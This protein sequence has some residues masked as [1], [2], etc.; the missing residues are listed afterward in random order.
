[1]SA[2]GD[3]DLDWLVAGSGDFSA[4]TVLDVH[5]SRHLLTT[6]RGRTSFWAG[7]ASERRWS[8]R[9]NMVRHWPAELTVPK[10]QSPDGTTSGGGETRPTP[11]GSASQACLV[12]PRSPAIRPSQSKSYGS[13]RAPSELWA[14][15]GMRSPTPYGQG[16]HRELLG[17]ARYQLEGEADAAPGLASHPLGSRPS[18][19]TRARHM[20]THP[21]YVHDM[22]CL[23]RCRPLVSV[24]RLG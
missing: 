7:R 15:G 19:A 18:Q 22:K 13:V 14:A 5:E 12:H 3:P 9:R 6:S 23:L 17:R 11:L 20:D 4:P 10:R 24:R 21:S 1:V 2:R 8:C 16:R